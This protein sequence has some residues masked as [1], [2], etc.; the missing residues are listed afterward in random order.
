MSASQET[1]GVF[2]S[3]PLDAGAPSRRNRGS[4]VIGR[5][6]FTCIELRIQVVSWEVHNS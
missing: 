5:H 3:Q 4:A 2:A 1:N 6:S